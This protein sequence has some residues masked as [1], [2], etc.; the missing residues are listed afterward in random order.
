MFGEANAIDIILEEENKI[1]LKY[2][3]ATMIASRSSRKSTYATWLR[4]YNEGDDNWSGY[5]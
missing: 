1:K 2:L 3:A 5:I 4:F